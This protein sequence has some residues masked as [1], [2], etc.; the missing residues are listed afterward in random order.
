MAPTKSQP[1]LAASKGVTKSIVSLSRRATST[2]TQHQ[3]V[4]VDG[5]QNVPVGKRKADASP[6]R[7]E[8]GV[9]RSALGNVTNAVLNAIEDSKKLTR[10]KVDAKKMTTT[11]TTNKLNENQAIFVAP[12]AIQRGTKVTTRAASR[13]IETTKSIVNEAT[14]GL[15]K[16]NISTTIVKGKKKTET[17]TTANNNNKIKAECPISKTESDSNI[18]LK[19]NVRRLS[20]EF[21]L[22]DNE[23]SHYMSALEDL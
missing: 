15:K 3:K 1:T 9:K 17:I 11:L 5:L 20:N 18:D 10:S 22:L 16:V 12:N 4:I 23:D 13:A 6:V 8:K 7:N 19:A 21:D 14:A 2:R